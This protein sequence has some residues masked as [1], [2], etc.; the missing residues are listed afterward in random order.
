MFLS[1]LRLGLRTWVSYVYPAG[2]ET[3]SANLP[4]SMFPPLTTQTILS[5]P[6]LPALPVSPAA[7]AHAAA[8]SQMMWFRAAT[9]AIAR[10]VSSSDVTI[11]PDRRRLANAHILG[12]TD[13]PPQP[14]T[15]LVF[16]SGNF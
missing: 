13:L 14:S 16:Q 5:L 8:P 3:S 4:R 12:K 10:R 6:P 2:D 1:R 9:S 11:E 15:K 7:T